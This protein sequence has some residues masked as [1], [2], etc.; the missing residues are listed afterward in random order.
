MHAAAGAQLN[1]GKKTAVAGKCPSEA[2]TLRRRDK[3][4]LLQHSLDC[5]CTL[6]PRDK[7]VD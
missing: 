7:H 5:N 6:W 3:S 2:A 1:I 4:A